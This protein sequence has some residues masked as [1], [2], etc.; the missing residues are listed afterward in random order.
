MA[1]SLNT[2]VDMVV[3]ATSYIGLPTYGKVMIGDRAFE[4]YNDKN[5]N[6]NVQIPWTEVKLVAASILFKGKCI[7]RFVVMTKKNGNY[8]FSTK[9]TRKL[10]T[11][12][13]SYV[14][15]DHIVR[16]LSFFDVFKRG[17]KNLFHRKK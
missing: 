1:K 16:S 14:D 13:K 4:F 15:P 8:T 2:K 3:K 11:H 5:V 10:L 9:E 6:D 7:P 12:M 17:I